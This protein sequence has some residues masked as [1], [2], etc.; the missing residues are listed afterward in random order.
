MSGDRGY[1]CLIL[2]RAKARHWHINVKNVVMAKI[3]G[4]SSPTLKCLNLLREIIENLFASENEPTIV[5]QRTFDPDEAPAVS[6][7]EVL[8]A[9]C[10]IGK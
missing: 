5:V 10:R 7:E 8:E 4:K 9:E 2:V 6:V 3:K 1:P